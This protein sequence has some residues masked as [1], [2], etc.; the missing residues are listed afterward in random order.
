MVSGPGS[1]YLLCMPY[2]DPVIVAQGKMDLAALS[3]DTRSVI[4]YGDQYLASLGRRDGGIIFNQFLEGHTESVAKCEALIVS[5]QRLLTN[6]STH[7]QGTMNEYAKG[8][9]TNLD[10]VNDLWVAL[11]MRE[12]IEPVGPLPTG[13]VSP[14]PLPSTSLVAPYSDINHWALNIYN[15]PDYLSTTGLA[16]KILNWIVEGL[17]GT[18]LNDWLW[19]WLGGDYEQIDVTSDAWRNLMEYFVAL[20]LELLV[21]MQ[22]MFQGW[23]DSAA[24]TTAGAYFAEAGAA[25]GSVQDPLG[26]MAGLYHST[27]MSSKS[28]MEATFSLL[29]AALE[30]VIAFLAGTLT[31]GGAVGAFFTFGLSAI[32]ASATAVIAIKETAAAF[33]KAIM[34]AIYAGA[35]FGF[36]ME[37][38]AT[39]I[40]WVSLPEG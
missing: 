38:A 22:N 3:D 23:Y 35:G 26:S 21:R 19:E 37:A 20:P 29:D 30:A 40:N 25:L 16:S 10:I 15:W 32:P 2:Y 4:Q 31:A 9:Q 1:G 18:S 27:A 6:A 7:V 28:F 12:G 14:G 39:E 8:E 11:E 17:F 33:W 5:T 36:L 13:S 24:A 34:T